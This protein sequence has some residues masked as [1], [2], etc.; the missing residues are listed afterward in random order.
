MKMIFSDAR[1]FVKKIFQILWTENLKIIYFRASLFQ[2][3]IY[4]NSRCSCRF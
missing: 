3:G 1:F 2:G 4:G